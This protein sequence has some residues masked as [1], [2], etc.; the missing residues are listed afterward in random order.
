MGEEEGRRRRRR[1]RR[2]GEGIQTGTKQTVPFN[3]VKLYS[4]GKLN[5]PINRTELLWEFEILYF[6]LANSNK[7]SQHQG[8]VCAAVIDVVET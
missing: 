2:G 8:H 6:K 5:K 3:A 4:L 1:K 7:T